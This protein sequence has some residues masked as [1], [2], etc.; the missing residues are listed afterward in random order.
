MHSLLY[1]DNKY[2]FYLFL[3]DSNYSK[4]YQ[5]QSY[6][7]KYLLN[8]YTDYKICNE[9]NQYYNIGDSLNISWMLFI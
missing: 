4:H 6:N 8:A 5:K 1:P 7:L 9:W 3:R 2:C